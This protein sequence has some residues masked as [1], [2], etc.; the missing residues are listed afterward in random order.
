MEKVGRKLCSR[1]DHLGK[2]KR[3]DHIG[4]GFCRGAARGVR[5]VGASTGSRL[6]TAKWS[7]VLP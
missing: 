2:C 5:K 1:F 7:Q 6:W 4:V 3:S